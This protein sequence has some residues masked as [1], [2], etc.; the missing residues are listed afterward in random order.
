VGAG[1]LVVCTQQLPTR[2]ISLGQF[3][4]RQL[5]KEK[6]AEAIEAAVRDLLGTGRAAAEHGVREQ[7]DCT[8]GITSCSSRTYGHE[9]CKESTHGY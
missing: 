2:T 6:E 1:K 8:S 3:S 7:I 4:M 9:R 5:G